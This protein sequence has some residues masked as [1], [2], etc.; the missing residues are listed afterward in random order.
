MSKLY[1]VSDPLIFLRGVLKKALKEGK[2]VLVICADQAQL[3]ELSKKLW[4]S[5]AFLPHTADV[6]DHLSY[7]KIFLG[8]SEDNPI[9]ADVIINYC[10]E[11]AVID[12]ISIQQ[13]H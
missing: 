6:T 12:A 1:K 7:Q 2:K 11:S 4:S 10:S 3:Q 5:R 13:L 8:L 9:N